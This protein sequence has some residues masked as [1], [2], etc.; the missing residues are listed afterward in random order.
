[1]S[2]TPWEYIDGVDQDTPGFAPAEFHPEAAELGEHLA[3][4]ADLE[5]ARTGRDTRCETCTFRAGTPANTTLNVA[6]AMKCTMEGEPFYC[7]ETDRPCGGWVALT[8][9]AHA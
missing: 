4:F 9:E 3:R 7:H 6:N 8:V 1:M 2:V 5:H